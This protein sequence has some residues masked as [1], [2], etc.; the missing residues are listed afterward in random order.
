M[1]ARLD[2]TFSDYLLRIGNGEEESNYAVEIQFPNNMT[3][4]YIDEVAS[5]KELLDVVFPEIDVYLQKLE[6]LIKRVILTPKMTVDQINNLIM[7][8]FPGD[9]VKYYSFGAKEKLPVMLLRNSNP[10]EGL[11]NGTR[12]I[13]RQFDRNII[14]TEI[15]VGEHSGKSLK[16]L[17]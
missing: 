14:D 15:A 5:L 1:R 10:A 13:C 16:F 2:P 3:I 11:C 9:A 7:A 6:T 8:R 12:V 17:L 4:P